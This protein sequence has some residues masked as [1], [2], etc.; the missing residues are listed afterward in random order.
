MLIV[1]MFKKQPKTYVSGCFFGGDK[2]DRT[3]DLLNAMGQVSKYN[4]KTAYKWTKQTDF[5][6]I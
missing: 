6:T 4:R 3:A 2:R 1:Q 5:E